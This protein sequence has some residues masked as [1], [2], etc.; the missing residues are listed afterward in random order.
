MRAFPSTSGSHHLVPL[1]HLPRHLNNRHSP[2]FVLALRPLRRS[3][4]PHSPCLHLPNIHLQIPIRAARTH[5]QAAL[6]PPPY[7]GPRMASHL[8]AAARGLTHRSSTVVVGR[9][10]SMRTSS[11]NVSGA[12]KRAWSYTRSLL[13]MI[14]VSPVLVSF[15]GSPNTK[16]VSLGITQLFD[17]L[18]LA[19]IAKKDIIE[20]E[21]EL[22][23]HD[24]IRLTL[25]TTPTWAAQA[26]EEEAR[27]K[28]AARSHVSRSC[29]QA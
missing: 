13:R 11:T 4:P 18:I 25:T 22:K 28:A 7:E 14:W 24:S 5:H 19:I 26:D 6:G 3:D 21:N 9:M 15:L 12:L 23:R 20:Q 2:T 8:G 16:N 29:C 10:N 17:A 27:E 1:L